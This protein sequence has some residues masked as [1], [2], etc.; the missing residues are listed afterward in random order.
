MIE[1][2]QASMSD[3]NS[4]FRIRN[5][6]STYQYSLNPREVQEEEH[7]IWLQSLVSQSITNFVCLVNQNVAGI[8]YLTSKDP[9]CTFSIYLSSEYMG[10]GLGKQLLLHT[11]EKS[12]SLGFKRYLA[13]IHKDNVPSIKIFESAGFQRVHSKNNKKDFYLFEYFNGQESD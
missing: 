5:Q 10:F 8:C 11:L 1:F 13:E 3:L 2:R 9:I 4:L 6:V 7:L 12:K